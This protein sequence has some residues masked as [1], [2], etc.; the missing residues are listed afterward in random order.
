ML[1]IE[2]IK[3]KKLWEE[4]LNKTEFYPFFQS[5]G[6]GEVQKKLGFDILRFG[7]FEE[8][9]VVSVFLIVDVKAK[10]GHYLH[11]RH[12]PVLN[13]FKEKYFDEIIDFTRKIG[14]ER[15]A[16]FIRMSPQIL[17]LVQDNGKSTNPSEVFFKS[18]GFINAPIHNMDA[19]NCWVLNLNQTEEEMLKQMR[20]T[21]RYLIR[22]AQNMD[23]KIIR[24]KNLSDIENFINIY[25]QLSIRKHF[26]P[27]KG[28][29]EEFEILAANDEAV[30][31]LAEYQKKIISGAL[32]VF[33]GN[34]AIYHHG[35]SSDEYREVPASYLIQWEA[36]REAKRRGKKIYNFWG[37]VPGNQPNHPWK[38][39][40]LFKTGFGGKRLDFI[41]AQDL[42][43]NIWYWKSFL[44]EYITKLKK[45]Y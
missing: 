33:I 29:K 38:G 36:I 10:R 5:W 31:F 20:K 42:P 35:V 32:I 19:Q 27:H 7:L 23:I 4:F 44:I 11:L 9:N 15:N 21:H 30:L 22:K 18:R 12:G 16:A 17:H 39:I 14:K 24:S 1:K 8:K 45:G 43:L 34:M 41:H 6:F 2:E 25:N 3:N 13:D 26:V 40:T 37:I 28:I